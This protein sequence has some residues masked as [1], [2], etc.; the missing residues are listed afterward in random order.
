V[1]TPP[2]IAMHAATSEKPVLLTVS[3]A[4]GDLYAG[5]LDMDKKGWDTSP[6]RVKLRQMVD[7]LLYFGTTPPTHIPSPPL[8]R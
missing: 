7:L 8:S 4:I 1:E 6:N 3:E 2:V 5:Y